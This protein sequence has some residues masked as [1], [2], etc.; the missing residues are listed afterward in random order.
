[1]E[2]SKHVTGDELREAVRTYLSEKWSDSKWDA[3]DA[4]VNGYILSLAQ[5]FI[6]GNDYHGR[7]YFRQR[8]N[9]DD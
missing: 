8:L 5:K 2:P 4:A 7:E 1:M 9:L 6:N 3:T